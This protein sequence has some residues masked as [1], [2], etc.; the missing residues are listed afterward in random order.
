MTPTAAG[1]PRL[2]TAEEYARIPDDGRKT[3]LVRGRI[4]EGPPTYAFPS[5]VCSNIARAVGNFV[6]AGKLGR[7]MTNDSGVVTESRSRDPSQ[8]RCLLLQL[9]PPAGWTHAAGSPISR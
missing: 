3:E 4:V 5:Y 6:D 7:V 2:L 8:C 9:H 1:P